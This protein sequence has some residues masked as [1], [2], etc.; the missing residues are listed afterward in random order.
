MTLINKK[1][2]MNKKINAINL[3]NNINWNMRDELNKRKE[4]KRGALA[5][6]PKIS[7]EDLISP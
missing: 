5:T 3:I 7:P 4:K 6:R 1:K 2:T